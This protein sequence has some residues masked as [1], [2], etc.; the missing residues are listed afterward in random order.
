[1]L[2]KD[3]GVIN[4]FVNNVDIIKNVIVGKIVDIVL[5]N[6]INAYYVETRNGV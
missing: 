4:V 5:S 6:M 1:M 3:V 2:L